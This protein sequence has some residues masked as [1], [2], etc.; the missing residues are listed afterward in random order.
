[1][2][3]CNICGFACS[4][5][6][7]KRQ[8]LK[9]QHHITQLNSVIP[10]LDATNNTFDNPQSQKSDNSLPF[11]SIEILHFTSKY[12]IKQVKILP[13]HPSANNVE[14]VMKPLG[15]AMKIEHL[16]KRTKLKQTYFQYT[17]ET[18]LIYTQ[19]LLLAHMIVRDG[20]RSKLPHTSIS[21]IVVFSARDTDNCVKTQ[22]VGL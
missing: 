18:L 16:Q 1:M 7:Q 8:L 3:E 19:L 6:Q 13:G 20:Y 10:V 21:E 14:R 2:P 12:D 15:K 4:T 22:Q 5:P 11:N 9:I 17:T